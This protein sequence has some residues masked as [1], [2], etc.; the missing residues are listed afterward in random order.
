[1]AQSLAHVFHSAATEL[2]QGVRRTT[3]EGNLIELGLGS[4]ART[5]SKVF[6]TAQ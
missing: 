3:S 5:T 4:G 2:L 6:S 1:M